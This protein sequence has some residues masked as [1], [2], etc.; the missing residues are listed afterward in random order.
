MSKFWF[1]ISQSAM[2]DLERP[3]GCPRKWQET[4]INRNRPEPSIYM[5]EGS[6]F[7]TKCLGSGAVAGQDVMDLPRLKSGE[8]STKHKRIDEQVEAF[9]SLIND[10]LK[11]SMTEVQR[12]IKCEYK[13]PN[14]TIVELR[15]VTDF[16]TIDDEGTYY[17]WDLK[18]TGDVDT[19][20]GPY[21]WGDLEMF[22]FTQPEMYKFILKQSSPKL[23][24]R[25]FL[26]VF[27]TKPTKG[28]KVIEVEPDDFGEA[29]LIKRMQAFTEVLNHYKENGY[30]KY[31][32]KSECKGCLLRE[33]CDK[34]YVE[35]E[36]VEDK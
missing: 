17:V 12:V 8:K 10:E 15:G 18:L 19:T 16:E 29:V 31:P 3:S 24:P 13:L 26:A 36:S 21:P 9:K 6:Y 1:T 34:V 20:F 2:K 25:M 28:Q 5:K 4:W 23:E 27:D 22:D 14:G 35:K 33:K 11:H 32:S 30:T 7:E